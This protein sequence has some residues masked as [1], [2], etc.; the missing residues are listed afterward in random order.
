MDDE[1]DRCRRPTDQE[2][3]ARLF[4]RYNLVSAAVV[5]EADRLVGVITVDDIVDVIEEEADEDI[6]RSA[7]SATKS[8]RT[9]S[10]TS[11]A[12]ASPGCSSTSCTALLASSV[13]SLFDATIEQ[14]VALAVLMPIV[15]SMGGNA[16]TQTMTVAVRALATRD[17]GR[18]NAWRVIRR[19]MRRSA[20]STASPSRSS[21]RASRCS[22]SARPAR[23]GDR[24]RHPRHPRLGGPRRH[25][26]P[27][28]STASASTRR[29]LRPPRHDDHRRRRLLRL[30]RH[31]DPVVRALGARR[32]SGAA[33][34]SPEP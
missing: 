3:V 23:P 34:R 14:M 26:I 28:A 31:R 1:P 20:S 7:A 11:C 12:A 13:I 30:P 22:G 19:E 15:A 5:D 33:Q 17:L 6:K 4:E 9:A 24:P 10:G 21:S 16:G 32:H 2:D 18:A 25:P 27:L 29:S 8:F